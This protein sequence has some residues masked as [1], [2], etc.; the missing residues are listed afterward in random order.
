MAHGRG[1]G[2]S[3]FG[4]DLLVLRRHGLHGGGMHD[5][6]GGEEVGDDTAGA[7]RR[8][9]KLPRSRSG[10]GSRVPGQDDAPG[11]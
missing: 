4:P 5:A 3:L 10:G 6:S 8:R 7:R 11:Q 1:E 9:R 2:I